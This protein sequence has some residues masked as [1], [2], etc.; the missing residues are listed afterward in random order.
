MV[1]VKVVRKASASIPTALGE[2]TLH[3]Y[4]NNLDDKEHLA[5]VMGEVAGG[6]GVLVRVHSECFTGDVLA[7]QRCDCG[8]QLNLSM[9]KIAAAGAGI[10]LYMRQEGRGIGLL[11]KLRAYALQDQGLDTVDANLALGHEPDERDY[12][13]A[14]RMLQDLGVRSV[15]LMTNNPDKIEALRALGVNVVQRIAVQA[16]ANADNAAYLLTKASRM[17]H[18]LDLDGL[19]PLKSP[20][21]PP[22]GNGRRPA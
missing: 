3:L 16:P 19:L 8:E 11:D 18:L 1:D 7:S 12:S 2:F 14:A 17:N 21:D 5:L 6:S 15:Q 4:E 13:V 20:G 22:D 10:V 9:K